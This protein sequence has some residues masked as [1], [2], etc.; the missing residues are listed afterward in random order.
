MDNC[1]VYLDCNGCFGIQ[2]GMCKILNINFVRRST[3]LAGMVMP[4]WPPR[5]KSHELIRIII[6][7]Q[8]MKMNL[9]RHHILE[10]YLIGRK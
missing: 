7:Y 3:S 9:E 2:I 8:V 1:T 5:G 10:T 4:E 6:F